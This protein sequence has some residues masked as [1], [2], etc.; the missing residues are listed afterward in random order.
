MGK[1]YVYV[2]WT[3]G[4]EPR[5]YYVGTGDGERIEQGYRSPEHE[6]YARAHGR[7][8]RVVLETDDRER[9]LDK[10]RELMELLRTWEHG[11]NKQASRG[12]SKL[13]AMKRHN[14][15]VKLDDDVH[16]AL[17]KHAAA[18]HTTMQALLEAQARKLAQK[19]G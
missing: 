5:P 19:G 11:F 4:S 2:D 6:A 10:E 7:D 13:T 12:S 18:H 1:S 17:K 14:V 3:I 16:V 8:R 15:H 9:A